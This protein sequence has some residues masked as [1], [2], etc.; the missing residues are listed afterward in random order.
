MTPL[1]YIVKTRPAANQDEEYA[2]VLNQLV[3][4]G[5]PNAQNAEG[6]TPLHKAVLAGNQ[7]AVN[8]L[9]EHGPTVINAAL[10]N[11]NKATALDLAKKQGDRAV[12]DAIQQLFDAA[13]AEFP[14]STGMML[15]AIGSSAQGTIRQSSS[16]EEKKKGKDKAS[17]RSK[18]KKGSVRQRK[19]DSRRMRPEGG[20][21]SEQGRRKTMEDAHVL[22][23]DLT[24]LEVRSCC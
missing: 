11:N 16:S 4:K 6:E 12:I 15:S 7:V 1:H 13:A 20:V 2:K 5:T 23:D 19:K 24:C 10:E 14:N 18:I 9:L 8:I 21:G 3:E 17:L 22:I